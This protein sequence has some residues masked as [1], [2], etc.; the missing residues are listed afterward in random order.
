MYIAVGSRSSHTE[1]KADSLLRDFDSRLRSGAE[2]EFAAQV[3]SDSSRAIAANAARQIRRF[4]ALVGQETGAEVI[5]VRTPNDPHALALQNRGAHLFGA[6]ASDVADLTARA[7]AEL[8]AALGYQSI[9]SANI[10]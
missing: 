4:E 9:V 5:D 10:D 7:L 6:E 3:F 8:L 1:P 2:P